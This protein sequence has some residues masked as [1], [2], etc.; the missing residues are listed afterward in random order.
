MIADSNR[1]AHRFVASMD[2]SDSL[3]SATSV[4][5][6]GGIFGL[7]WDKSHGRPSIRLMNPELLEKSVGADE[8][9]AVWL[10]LCRSSF[11]SLIDIS[12]CEGSALESLP[13]DLVSCE[14]TAAMIPVLF[15]MYSKESALYR[16]INH[17][18]RCFPIEL[19]SKCEKELGGI[20]SYIALLQS[21]IEQYSLVHPMMADCTVYR[22]F[23]SGWLSC[24]L[25]YETMVGEVIVWRG[26]SS[27]SLDRALV[28]S[29]FVKSAA[30]VL[31]EIALPA[32]AVAVSIAEFSEY[33]ES[34]VLI[35][36]S[37]GF[38]VDS[39][40]LVTVSNAD[41]EF[42]IPCVR[43]SYFVSWRDFDLSHRPPRFLL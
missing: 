36:A 16:N 33:D 21:S 28:I 31:F 29:S 26:F 27:A 14:T 20:L 23:G 38:L 43:L 9:F 37:T 8:C 11:R 4:S 3:V 5:A 35:A 32:G 42:D 15:K 24:A 18:L 30:G 40:D 34:E 13:S 12:H 10:D 25:L 22:G 39:V 2:E 7:F 6:S 41:E 17:F 1:L 19:V